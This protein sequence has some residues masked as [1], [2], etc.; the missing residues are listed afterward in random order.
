MAEGVYVPIWG[1]QMEEA[2]VSEWLKAEGDPVSEGEAL[3]II[4]T[5]KISGEVNSPADGVMKRRVG[6]VGQVLKVGAL[7]AVVGAA[8]DPETEVERVIREMPF[9]T[10]QAV[11]EPGATPAPATERAT[12]PAAGEIA[13]ADPDAPLQATPLARKMARDAGLDI[14]TV[15]GSGENGRIFARDVEAALKSGPASPAEPPAEPLAEDRIVPLTSLRRAIISKTM[16]TVDIPYGA[17]SRTVQ[18]DRLL[19][20]RRELADAFERKHGLKFS[21]THLLFKAAAQALGEVPIL[22]ARLDGDRIVIHGGKNIGMVVTPPGGGGIMIPVIR[23][24]QAKPLDRIAR[25]WSGIIGRVRS[26]TQTMEDLTGGTFTISNVGALG[27]DVFTPVIHPPESAILGVSRIV[28]APVVRDGAIVVGRTLSLI[29]GAD[30]RV[31][32]ADPIGEFLAAMDRIFQ[33]PAE[34]LI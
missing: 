13:D 6:R 3:L 16:Q 17:L 28:E 34:M 22:N 19:D 5:Y 4:E 2:T 25:E 29:I 1:L 14:R 8:D 7:L 10:D 27:I 9:V 24:V 23:N 26:G 32:D 12:A 18:V 31:F 33:N 11:S 20:F 30:H 15:T 21:L